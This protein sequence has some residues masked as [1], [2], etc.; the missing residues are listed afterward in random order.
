VSARRFVVTRPAEHAAGLSE[1]LRAAGFEAVEI[2]AVTVEPPV[3]WAALDDVLRRIGEFEWLLLT[4]R[5]GVEFLFDRAGPEFAWPGG[6]RWAGIG[7]GTAA[8][9]HRRGIAEVWIPSRF[10]GEAVAREMPAVRGDRVLRVRAEQASETPSEGLRSRG[11]AVT[12]VVAYRTRPAPES[13]VRALAAAIETGVDGVIFTSAST[14]RGFLAL[15]EAAGA[16]PQ[17]RALPAVA[18]GPVTAAALSEYGLTPAA[19]AEQH[20]VPGLVAAVIA[21]T[22]S[23]RSGSHAARVHHA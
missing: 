3:S 7:S 18:I 16:L 13:S 17:V 21:M 23:E 6:L 19:M 8:A 4:S 1:A 15:A 12:D 20:S 5:T 22:G 10:L 14:V 9:L 2:P 11:V